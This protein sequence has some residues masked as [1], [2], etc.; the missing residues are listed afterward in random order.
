MPFVLYG[1]NSTFYGVAQMECNSFTQSRIQKQLHDFE[2]TNN[3]PK[4]TVCCN[5]TQWLCNL[6][7]VKQIFIKCQVKQTHTHTPFSPGLMC[8]FCMYYLFR[9]ICTC[10]ESRWSCPVNCLLIAYHRAS[11]IAFSSLTGF[12]Q[13][14]WTVAFTRLLLL[15]IQCL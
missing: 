6:D 4:Y 2:K 14:H 5:L 1:F 10:C 3:N 12:T 15:K 11:R 7:D 13:K 9:K 8:H